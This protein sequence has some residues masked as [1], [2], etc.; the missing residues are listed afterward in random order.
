MICVARS[1]HT[2]THTR[3]H[4]LTI[5]LYQETQVPFLHSTCHKG[6]RDNSKLRH[7]ANPCL[8][9]HATQPNISYKS[10]HGLARGLAFTMI[11]AI[12]PKEL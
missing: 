2:V 12:T 11:T 6:S 3:G 10:Q 9:I 5:W 1:G 4:S 8:S 7:N